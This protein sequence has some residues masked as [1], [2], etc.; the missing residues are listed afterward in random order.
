MVCVPHQH[1]GIWLVLL[2]DQTNIVLHVKGS[3][4][5]VV[6]NGLKIQ[7]QIVLDCTGSVRLQVLVVP[8]VQLSRHADVVR[9]SDHHVDVGG[10]EGVAAHYRKQ[11]SRGAGGV[12]GVLSRFKAVEPEFTVFV[13]AE[14][15]SE[16]VAGLIFGVEDVVLAVG[17][18][19]PH[20]EDSVRD[21]LAGVDVFDDTMEK[22]ELP[23]FWHVLDY[24]GAKL[25]E[26][27]FRGPERSE[28]SGG[29]GSAAIVCNNLVV[30]L[31]DETRQTL[32]AIS[33]IL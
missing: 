2:R 27:R 7:K 11:L 10:A 23:V 8:R 29:R 19:L 4:V 30:D 12:N 18:G 16:V 14:L 13:G 15:A 17:A 32:L 24:V 3:A 26:W 22:R 1:S 28:N 31:V 25:P 33:G 6:L 21:A 9:M 5:V 20:V